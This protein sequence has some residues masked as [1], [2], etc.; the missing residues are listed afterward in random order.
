MWCA[1]DEGCLHRMIR[2]GDWKLNYYH[3]QEPQLFDLKD[4]PYEW[5]DRAKD[6]ACREVREALTEKVLE[7]WNPEVAAEKMK[8]KQADMRILIDWACH[9]EPEERY[10]WTLLPEMDYLD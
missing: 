6:P 1:T 7:D 10:R 9:T 3:G 4:D 5:N 8:A 2:S